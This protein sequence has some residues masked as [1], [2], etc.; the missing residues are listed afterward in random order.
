VYRFLLVALNIDAVLGEVTIRQRRRK[1]EEMVHGNR[2]SDA[3][4]ETLTRIKAQKGNKAVLGLKVLMW[5][6]YS[7]RQLRAQELC[8]A[9]GVEIGSSDLDLENIP[10]LRTLL[11]SCLGLVTIEESSSTV[12]L[13]HFTLQEHLL[14][15]PT[16]FRNPHSTIG[17]ICL[18]YLNYRSV[19][20]LSPTLYPPLGNAPSGVCFL[21]LGK[22]RKNGDDG[23]CQNSCAEA[24]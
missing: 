8:H 1:L 4:A 22:A 23:K 17:E 2:Q 7:E 18:T 24:S 13:A 6:L 11:A 15:N 19:C 14:S 20:D 9:L 3:Y 5:V 16:L 10:A 12:R 21:L